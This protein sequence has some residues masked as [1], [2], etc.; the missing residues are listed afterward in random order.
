MLAFYACMEAFLSEKIPDFEIAK[1]HD[2]PIILD[3]ISNVS[4]YVILGLFNLLISPL[5]VAI[6]PGVG[7]PW[8]KRGW[9][10]NLVGTYSRPK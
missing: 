3:N 7:S 8:M 2:T 4:L 1:K 5:S 10:W 9:V 6:S